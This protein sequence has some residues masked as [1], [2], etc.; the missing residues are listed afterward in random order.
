LRFGFF[1][2]GDGAEL[3]IKLDGRT[4]IYA[5]PRYKLGPV[6]FEW[7]NLESMLLSEIDR[8]TAL[9]KERKGAVDFLNPF[10]PPWE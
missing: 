1:S 5:F 10:P 6:L 9:F 8:M 3:A 2:A 7:A 4:R